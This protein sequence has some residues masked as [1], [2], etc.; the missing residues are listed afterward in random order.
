[1]LLLDAFQRFAERN[2]RA[3]SIWIERLKSIRADHVSGIL[4]KVPA[5]R[6]TPVCLRFT[7]ELLTLNSQRLNRLTI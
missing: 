3:A 2:R 5:S 6:M 7:L 4:E 1:L